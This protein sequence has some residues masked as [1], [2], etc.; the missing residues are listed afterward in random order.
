MNTRCT[1]T[2]PTS[3]NI[4]MDA[5]N[6]HIQ[7]HMQRLNMNTRPLMQGGKHA[8]CAAFV[9]PEVWRS[10]G[11]IFA[12][13]RRSREVEGGGGGGE[14]WWDLGGV[15]WGGVTA[16]YQV[17][18]LVACIPPC[19]VSWSAGLG[20]GVKLCRGRTEG[21]TGRGREAGSSWRDD[22]LLIM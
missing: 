3:S 10:H 8:P 11:C 16:D 22:P 12:Y 15:G 5:R 17:F 19:A 14:E 7:P 18:P 20:E 6:T 9:S 4:H 13:E 21:R 1:Q 2:S